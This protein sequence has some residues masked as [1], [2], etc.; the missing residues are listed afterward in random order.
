MRPD[1]NAIRHDYISTDIGQRPLAEKYGVKYTTLRRRSEREGWVEQ[2]DAMR[3]KVDAEVT[4][5]TVEAAAD[6]AAIARE[7]Q[8]DLL[9]RLRRISMKYPQDATEV[10][11]QKD[12]KTMVY[13]LTDLTKAYRDL[14]EDIVATSSDIEDL[15]PLVE[16]LQ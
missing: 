13:K 11:Q 16:M 10:R 9:E 8:R 14:T 5:K 6:N 1:W 3:R 7:I 15:N 2:R 4:Q 12:G